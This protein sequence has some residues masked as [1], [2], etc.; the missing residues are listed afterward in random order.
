MILLDSFTDLERDLD[1][2]EDDDSREQD[3]D[4]KMLRRRLRPHMCEWIGC[5]GP[6]VLASVELLGVHLN[7]KHLNVVHPNTVS[8]T[9]FE[10][11]DGIH[12]MRACRDTTC[13]GGVSVLSSLKIRG[14]SGNIFQKNTSF[15]QCIVHTKV[16]ELWQVL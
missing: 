9:H 1:D 12:N 10:E 16:S 13:V 14:V 7:K 15:T 11:A 6:P 4:L 3:E 8:I 5:I 2:V